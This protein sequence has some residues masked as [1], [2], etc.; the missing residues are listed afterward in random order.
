MSGPVPSGHVRLVLVQTPREF[1]LD[2][3]LSIIN[4]LCHTPRKYLVFLGWCI[5]GVEGELA[6]NPEGDTLPRA[7]ALNDQGTYY[8]RRKGNGTGRSSS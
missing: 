3:P 2:I 5:L 1:Y 7:G 6:E 4:S 8:Y